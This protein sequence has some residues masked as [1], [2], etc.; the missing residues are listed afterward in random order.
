M[1]EY[2][3][4]MEAAERGDK[5]ATASLVERKADEIGLLVEGKD[6]VEEIVS[7]IKA[8]DAGPGSRFG[9]LTNLASDAVTLLRAYEQSGMDGVRRGI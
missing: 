3:A 1:T 8:T 9:D 4:V 7:N 6:I 5:Q 2:G